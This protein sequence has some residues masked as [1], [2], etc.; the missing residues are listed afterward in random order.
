MKIN[1][2][3][4]TGSQSTKVNNVNN[5]VMHIESYMLI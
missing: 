2:E 4:F 1:V 3:P 5:N